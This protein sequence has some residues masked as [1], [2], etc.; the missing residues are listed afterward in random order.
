MEIAPTDRDTVFQNGTAEL[1]RFRPS[2]GRRADGPPVLLVPSLIN[3]WYVL[4]LRPGASLVEVLVDQGFET[5][6]IDWG[7]PEDEDRFLEWSEVLARLRRMVSRTKRHADTDQLGMLGYCM[8]GTLCAIHMALHPDSV[9]SYVS[10]TAPIDFDEAGK[11]GRMVDER[12]FDAE[13]IADAG[14][15]HPRQMQSGFVALDPTA[16]ISK[17]VHLFDRMPDRQ[18]LDAFRALE[19]WVNDNVPFPASAYET[20]ISELYQ[21]NQ[22]LHGDHHVRG[23]R[24]DLSQIT[25]PLLTLAASA[26][27]ICPP[28]SARALNDVVGSEHTEYEIVSGGH[29]GALVGSKGPRQLYPRISEW[30]D[31]TLDSHDEARE[32]A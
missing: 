17:W 25:S 27:H 18:F 4:D 1:Y 5:Y 13:S 11:L 29:V 6:C 24:V 2:D 28:R 23:R 12:W 10:L 19:T 30:F 3:R 7:I 26:D 21:Q 9:D 32:V 16:Q 8:G 22:L 31:E 14:N 15:V 20:Y